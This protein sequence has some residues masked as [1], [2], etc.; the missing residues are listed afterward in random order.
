L[1]T[2]GNNSPTIIK[3]EDY[4]SSLP[5]GIISGE[6]V[7]LPEHSF[8]KIFE[9]VDLNEKDVFYH[10]GCGNGRGIA[11]AS[12]EFGVKKAV[13]ID[14]NS[15]KIDEAKKILDEKKLSNT[16]VINE[17]I[18]NSQFDDASVI[19]FWFTDTKIIESM[20]D[21][22]TKMGNECKIITIWGPLP[23]C[24]PD[25]IDFP[26]IINQIPFKQARD[27]KEQLL[28]VFGSKCIDFV[29][30]W[31]F[32]ERYTKAI[33]APE[34]GNDRFLTIIQ[35]LVIWINAKNLGV[36]CTDEIP[37]AIKN[38]MGILRNFFNIEVE[39]LLK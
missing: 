33:G 8:R 24:L 5:T 26:Y 16:Q 6:D 1:K 29:N 25:Q 12:E 37:P 7:Q 13:G 3:L 36:A 10:L 15:K 19:L 38:Y 32:A 30:A 34:A 21:K 9:F 23:G 39:H 11:I 4:L 17:N 35:S 28:A 18:L 2:S 14:I 22:F 31:E 20:M 27:L